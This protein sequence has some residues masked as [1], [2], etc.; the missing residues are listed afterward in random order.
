M[1][2][3]KIDLGRP[4]T[5]LGQKPKLASSLL[6]GYSRPPQSRMADNEPGK[7]GPMTSTRTYKPPVTGTKSKLLG[8]ILQLEISK[9]KL[10]KAQITKPSKKEK[11]HFSLCHLASRNTKVLSAADKPLDQAP[12]MPKVDCSNTPLKELRQFEKDFRLYIRDD[13]SELCTFTNSACHSP[14]LQPASSRV[15]AQTARPLEAASYLV[16][17]HLQHQPPRSK[18]PTT[19][20]KMIEGIKLL[21]GMTQPKSKARAAQYGKGLATGNSRS[22]H[23]TEADLYS[24]TEEESK[25]GKRL[26]RR[27]VSSRET[28]LK[29]AA[30]K[31]CA[32]DLITDTKSV[33]PFLAKGQLAPEAQPSSQV[34]YSTRPVN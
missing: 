19:L 5:V 1:K 7:E 3:Q 26:N 11:L 20:Q 14:M 13:D 30:C 2:C 21:K 15:L 25:A 22:T 27:L 4:T 23:G 9:E 31:T 34:V 24:V 8:S 16:G 17:D 29:G 28:S 32:S 6:G 33:V 12:M 18:G 10:A